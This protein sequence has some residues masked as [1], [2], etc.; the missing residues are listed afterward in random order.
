MNLFRDM[1]SFEQRKV[2]SQNI[3]S[4][5]PERCPVIVEPTKDIVLDK[6]K[7]LVPKDLTIGQFIYVL[8]KRTKLEEHE[9]IYI[10][11]NEIMPPTS[12]LISGVYQDNRE[13]DGF[14]YC[15]LMKENTF[16]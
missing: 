10:F 6:H 8:R 1:K 4:K 5:Y 12:A 16:G 9:S 15:K 13:P 7:Y 11:V 3:M 2:E 14:L